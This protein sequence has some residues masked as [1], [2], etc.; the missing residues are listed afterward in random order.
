MGTGPG[1]SEVIGTG[2]VPWVRATLV[3]MLIML[4][5]TAHGIVRN[6]FIAAAIGDLRARQWGV[7]VGSLLVL[8]VTLLLWRWM[9][10]WTTRA[11]LIVGGYWVA[12][13][14]TF[15]FSLGHLTG[16]TWSRIL[17]DYNPARGGFM[18]FG[19]V[20]MFFAPWMVAR[21]LAYWKK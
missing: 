2:E 17:G 6:V 20:V 21:W 15:E 5:E 8:L 7:L 14:L 1:S 19:L 10:A 13:T 12:L 3:W 16:L 4:L 9:K 18:L 11:Q